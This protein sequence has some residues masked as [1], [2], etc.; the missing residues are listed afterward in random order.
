M[1][2]FH[3][4]IPITAPIP[5]ELATILMCRTVSTKPMSRP[6]HVLIPIPMATVPIFA[7]DISSINQL[8]LHFCC[9]LLFYPL[10]MSSAK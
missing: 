1:V 5:M 8:Q 6:M 3:C 10:Q 7:T 9:F 4:P 2:C